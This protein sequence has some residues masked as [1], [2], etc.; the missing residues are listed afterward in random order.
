VIRFQAS[1]GSGYHEDAGIRN[2]KACGGAAPRD[3]A[4]SIRV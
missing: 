4:D 3:D 1:Q 2:L